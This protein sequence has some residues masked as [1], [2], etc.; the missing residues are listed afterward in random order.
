MDLYEK[1]DTFIRKRS[2]ALSLELEC[3]LFFAIPNLGANNIRKQNT[4]GNDYSDNDKNRKR[5][6]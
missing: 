6:E 2:S 1:K 5:E 4:E 3:C